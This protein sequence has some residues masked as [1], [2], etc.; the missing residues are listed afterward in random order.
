MR[1]LAHLA[2]LAAA[3]LLWDTAAAG[4]PPLRLGTNV[5]PGYEP[6]FLAREL[7]YLND[8]KVTL[9]EFLSASEV[10]RAFRNGS[11]EAAALTLDETLLLV[12]DGFAVR[13]FLVTDVSNGGDVVLARPSIQRFE[14]LKGRRIGVE[15]GALGAYVL[16]RA[17]ERHRLAVTD[18][19]LV[20][21]EVNE[22]RTAYN[23]GQ[24]DGVVT[25]EPVRSQLLEAGAR[26]VFSSREIPGEIVDVL[27]T[28]QHYLA[29]HPDLLRHLVH[30]WFGALDYLKQRPADAA[31]R[32][33]KRL[34]LSPEAV[35]ASY[36]GLTL[37]DREENLSLLGST[38]PK[39]RA[40]TERLQ[41]LLLENR[42]LQRRLHLD[43][44]LFSTQALE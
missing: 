6:L 27:V 28:H 31:A 19:E 1:L 39:L 5:W 29:E 32:M 2:L 38:T 36:E 13:I 23:A 25:F 12:Q 9:V 20:Y 15:T 18:V 42:L 40:T 44:A 10:I 30:G 11:L 4:E 21:L 14:Q 33:S 16:S 26:E 35:N 7:D 34:N 3:I 22:H 17:L 8:T 37:P 43:D 24:I 41:N